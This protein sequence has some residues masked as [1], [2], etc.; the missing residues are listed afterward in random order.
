MAIFL[1]KDNKVIVQGITGSEATIHT[2]RMLKA[3]RR[4]SAASTRARPGPPSHTR[5]RAAG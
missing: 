1:T 3:A 5:T 2:A 4:S